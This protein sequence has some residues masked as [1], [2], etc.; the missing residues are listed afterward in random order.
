[1]LSKK[2]SLC[3]K[4]IAV[5]FLLFHHLYYKS[6]YFTENQITSL[7][8][9]QSAIIQFAVFSKVCLCLFVFISGYGL[10]EGL[11]KLA[12]GGA[13]NKKTLMRIIQLLKQ[14]IFVFCVIMILS[15]FFIKTSDHTIMSYF[16]EGYVRGIFYLIFDM[17]CLSD[18][19]GTPMLNATWWYMPTAFF[20]ILVTPLLYNLIKKYDFSAVAVIFL[21][22]LILG[23][24]TNVTFEL[25][26]V[27]ALGIWTSEYKGFEKI[28]EIS[29][30]PIRFDNNKV[31]CLIA[32]I[33]IVVLYYLRTRLSMNY[34]VDPFFAFLVCL[35]VK[36]FISYIQPLY[37][38]LM[39]LGKYSMYIFLTHSFIKAYWFKSFTYS[40]H[41]YILIFIVL[42]FD[43]LLF[44]F[45]L[46]QL[47]RFFDQGI[48]KIKNNF[49]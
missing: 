40:F 9:K 12:K 39:I 17:F 13:Q 45:L 5:L 36:M 47:K 32:C 20:F 1:M 44:A 46:E 31:L 21:F 42:V 8:T 6:S 27:L 29:F 11:K 23:I 48:K 26:P 4:G 14:F 3:V 33:G 41:N 34:L 38:I 22:P 2:D 7:F 49:Q 30:G 18:L 37:L 25:L 35:L 43:C 24:K 15:F 28:Q 19:F 16:S 10:C